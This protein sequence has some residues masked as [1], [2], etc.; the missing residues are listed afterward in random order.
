MNR[1]QRIREWVAAERFAVIA[2]EMVRSGL[3]HQAEGRGE[4]PSEEIQRIAWSGE[5]PLTR[6]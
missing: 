5:L 3:H 6:C 2:E 1:S 4:G